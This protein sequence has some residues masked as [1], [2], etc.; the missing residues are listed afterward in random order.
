M[1]FG[2]RSTGGGGKFGVTGN[3]RSNGARNARTGKALKAMMNRVKAGF[4]RDL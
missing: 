3:N 2:E 4:G 1:G